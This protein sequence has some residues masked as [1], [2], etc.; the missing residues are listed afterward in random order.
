MNRD[1]AG[2]YA[3]QDEALGAMRAADHGLYLTGGTALARGYY[4]HRYSEDLDLFAN[5]SAEFG[6][7][8][9]RCIAALCSLCD[10]RGFGLEV[11]LREARFGR[12]F[13]QGPVALKVE[14]VNDV[15]CRIGKAWPQRGARGRVDNG[16]RL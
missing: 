7:W 15:P 11:A 10:A 8:R 9:D 4:G 13:L 14:F 6:L 3:L 1:W 2:L 12:L 5:D 16:N